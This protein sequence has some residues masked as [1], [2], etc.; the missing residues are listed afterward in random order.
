MSERKKA[1]IAIA[2]LSLVFVCFLSS[3]V[4][5]LYVLDPGADLFRELAF[6]FG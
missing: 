6:L 4:G 5:L 3:A 1:L 2:V